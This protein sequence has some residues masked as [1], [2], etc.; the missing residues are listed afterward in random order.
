[1]YN[2]RYESKTGRYIDIML[3]SLHV[4]RYCHLLQSSSFQ[5]VKETHSRLKPLTAQESGNH[6][7]KTFLSFLFAVLFSLQIV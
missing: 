6:I 7:W 3:A 2:L 5:L 4:T 1:M